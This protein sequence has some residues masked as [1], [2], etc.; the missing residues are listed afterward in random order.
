MCAVIGDRCVEDTVVFSY[1][2][3]DAA[4]AD[5]IGIVFE[6]RQRLLNFLGIPNHEGFVDVK[7]GGRYLRSRKN[8]R[9]WWRERCNFAK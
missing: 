1:C 7:E 8:A 4:G 2:R 5:V 3:S 9:C 6:G